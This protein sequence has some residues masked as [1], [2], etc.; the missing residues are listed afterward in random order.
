MYN[1][2]NLS[3][4]SKDQLIEL[5]EMY[6]KNWLALDG[7]WF[8]SIERKYGLDEAM[9][10]DIEAW[11]RYTVIEARRIKKFLGLSEHPGVEGLAQALKLRFYRNINEDR[12]EI[13][14][15]KLTYYI[16]NCRVQ[17]TR[18]RKGM[19]RHPCK[20]VGVVEF[21][22]FAKAIDDRFTTECISCYPDIT[23][24]SCSCKWVFTLNEE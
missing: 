14:G 20:N 17:S 4:Y 6:S 16:L 22:D 2:E 1:Y 13:N 23:D 9:Y 8:Q 19:E 5:I 24:E 12:I 7:V 11:K 21:G 18:V 3:Q 15:N 10:H